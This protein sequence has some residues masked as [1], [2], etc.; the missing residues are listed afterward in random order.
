MSANVIKVRA[1]NGIPAVSK[2]TKEAHEASLEAK[3]ILTQA[4]EQA[5]QLLEDARR[6]KETILTESKERGYAAGLDQWNDALADA[7][8]QREDF[9]ARHEPELVKLAVAVAKKIIV[10]N[11]E[12]DP[13][14]VVQT[15]REALRSVRSER[16]VTIKVN[17]S[18][19]VA[20]RAQASSLKMLG[21]EVGEL[22]IIGNPSIEAGG[23][24]VESD[25]GIIDA[26]IDT[27]LA[28]IEC[29]LLRRFDAGDR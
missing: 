20:L 19:E 17:P 3:D 21:A 13:G 14:T 5:A 16:R 9:L 29:A 1:N 23:C 2:I 6:E 12:V 7:W 24:I 10:R 18:D 25:L 4:Q 28:S 11:V 27:Q 8:K 22:V 15:A 26:R